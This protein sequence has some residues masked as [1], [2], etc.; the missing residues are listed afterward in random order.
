MNA[1]RRTPR[2]LRLLAVHAATPSYTVG[3]V[4]AL[5]RGNG[6]ML[7]VEQRHTGGW[8]LPGGLLGRGENAAQGLVREVSEEV[9]LTLDPLVLPV[10]QASLTPA[11]RR[12]DLVFVWSAGEDVAPRRGD[13]VEV[14]NVGWFPLHALPDVTEPTVEILRGVRLL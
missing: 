12:V 4:L 8:A 9:G 6:D 1:F 11:S 7:F 10:P 5:R 2:P 14:L 13:D 3:V